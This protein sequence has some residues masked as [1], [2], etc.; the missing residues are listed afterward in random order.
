MSTEIV[1]GYDDSEGSRA[2]LA[3]A[4]TLAKGLGSSIVLAFCFEP[5][6]VLA[7]GGAGAQRDVIESIGEDVL[8]R[9]IAIATDAGVSAR[10]ELV[11]ARPVEG[12]I[13]L[14]DQVDT[15]MIVVGHHGEGP[16]RGA[17]IGATANKL[18][19]S[20]ERPV[21]VVPALED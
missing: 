12:L 10:G 8:A 5:P 11:D 14:A 20:A 21:L 2:A 9:G 17:I 15:P 7:G 19:H 1:V 16:F 13:A 3:Q 18:L 6:A 4:I